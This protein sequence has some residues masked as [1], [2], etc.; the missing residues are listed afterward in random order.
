MIELLGKCSNFHVKIE[1][2]KKPGMIFPLYN[3]G[4]QVS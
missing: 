2:H 1:Q 4:L 3:F